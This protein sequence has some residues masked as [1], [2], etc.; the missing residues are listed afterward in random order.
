MD[1]PQP[2]PKSFLKKDMDAVKRLNG[3]GLLYK[4]L[5]IQSTPPE[6]VFTE[7]VARTRSQES[8]KTKRFFLTEKK[9][10]V[11][12]CAYCPYLPLCELTVEGTGSTKNMG[13][14]DPFELN[15]SQTL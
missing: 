2:I 5:K 11:G 1:N 13:K 10:F 12:I 14:E 8:A 15:S 9:I 6:M 7:R 3:D 4:R